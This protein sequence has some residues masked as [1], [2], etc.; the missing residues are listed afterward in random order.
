[1]CVLNQ[2]NAQA[3]RNRM[4]ALDLARVKNQALNDLEQEAQDKADILLARANSLRLEAEDEIK[5]LN[6]VILVLEQVHADT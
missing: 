6:E 5:H 1:M 3:T 4:K 2:E